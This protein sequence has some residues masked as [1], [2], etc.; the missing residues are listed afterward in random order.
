MNESRNEYDEYKVIMNA[1]VM[2]HVLFELM[3]DMKRKIS[4]DIQ[5][6][7]IYVLMIEWFWLMLFV[8]VSHFEGIQL[9]INIDWILLFS[10]HFI[11]VTGWF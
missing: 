5:D 2:K 8:G 4:G 11:D 7:E 10:F 6:N 9:F 1:V 3:M